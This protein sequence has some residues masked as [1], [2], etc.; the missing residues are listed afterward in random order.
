MKKIS[1]EDNI[2]AFPKQ[3]SPDGVSSARLDLLRTAHPDGVVI[4]GIGGSA[5]PGEILY[6]VREEIGFTAPVVLWRNYGLP[7]F[8]SLP[9][10]RPL[11]VVVSFSGNT[12]EPLSGLRM[13][14]HKNVSAGYLAIITT[15]GK[16]LEIAER[17]LLPL[18]R[19]T[20]GVLQPRQGTGFMFYGLSE[21]LRAAGL[22]REPVP[23]FTHLNAKKF[24]VEGQRLARA[25]QKRLIT[26]YTKSDE[27]FIGYLWKI[28]CNENA[29]TPAFNNVFPEM[30]HNELAGFEGKSFPAVALF[31]EDKALEKELRRQMD[32][33]KKLLARYGVKNLSVPLSGKTLFERTWNSLMLADWFSYF[34]AKLNHVDPK[35]TA[36]INELKAELQQ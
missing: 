35:A 30:D 20:A 24:R 5:L 12:A 4:V 27:R 26:I 17:E 31:L 29:K 19:F 33:T 22:L 25:V 15:G 36:I 21:I 1:F 11:Y 18:V 10:K 8:S 14:L 3:L 28:R 32:V 13:L 7:P 9:M 23:A 6:G 34:L 2:L 16:L